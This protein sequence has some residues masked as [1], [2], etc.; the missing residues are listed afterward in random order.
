MEST[1]RL[2]NSAVEHEFN[3]TLRVTEAHKERAA[4]LAT[5]CHT[6]D[7]VLRIAIELGLRELE[8]EKD[9]P[10]QKDSG[11]ESPS[12]SEYTQR[13]ISPFPYGPFERGSAD[14]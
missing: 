4:R 8:R 2:R 13:R 5:L 1:S 6:P 7:D 11:E 14:T 10:T 9:V 3:G 12:V